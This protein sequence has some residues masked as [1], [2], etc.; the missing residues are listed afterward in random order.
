MSGLK[1]NKDDVKKLLNYESDADR[2]EITEV[3]NPYVL[4]TLSH[5]DKNTKAIMEYKDGN[6]IELWKGENK[7]NKDDCQKLSD[8]AH[9]ISLAN[10][11]K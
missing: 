11:C 10:S 9:K 5:A 8:A 7:P 1:G 2:V 6:F 4:F 3:S